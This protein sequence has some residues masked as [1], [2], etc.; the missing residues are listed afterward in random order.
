M[1]AFFHDGF[2]LIWRK[3]YRIFL[4][5]FWVAGLLCGIV[6][7]CYWGDY[8]LS[9]MHRLSAAPVSIVGLFCTAALPFLL[10]ALAVMISQCWL[11]M[12]LG[13]G[14]AFLFSLISFGILKTWSSSGWLL[15]LLLM[16]GG[17]MHMMLHY[18]FC[19][20]CVF[21]DRKVSFACFF[22][23]FSLLLLISSMDFCVISPFLARIID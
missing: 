1:S 19:L 20:R 11:L 4:A 3:G 21:W 16:S 2:S 17:W 22:V 9:M 14:K 5:F 7:C 15:Q 8:F 23:L 12:I 18:L 10:S 13:F 6:T